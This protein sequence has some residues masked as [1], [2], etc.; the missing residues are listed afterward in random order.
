VKGVLEEPSNVPI[1]TG[2]E[3]HSKVRIAE[4]T[5]PRAIGGHASTKASD[6]ILGCSQ[7]LICEEDARQLLSAAPWFV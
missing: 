1:A 7:S 4:E 2:R 6:A 5:S 3:L